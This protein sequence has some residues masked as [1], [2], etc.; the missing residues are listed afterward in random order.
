MILITYNI[1]GYQPHKLDRIVELAN[2]CDALILTEVWTEIPDLGPSFSVINCQAPRKED[3][4]VGRESGGVSFIIPALVQFRVLQRHTQQEF[5]A[6]SVSI[7]G[8]P[9]VGVYLRPKTVLSQLKEFQ[10]TAL[11]LARG[12]SVIIGDLNARHSLW[13][14]ITPQAVTTQ[15]RAI[16]NLAAKH[17]FRVIAA[18]SS[19]CERHNGTSR[20]D[21]AL[22]RNIRANY[23]RVGDF[24]QE[25]SDHAPVMMELAQCCPQQVD[26]I[27]LNLINNKRVRERVLEKYQESLP[28]ITRNL[29]KCDNRDDIKSLSR[30]LGSATLVPWACEYSPNPNRWRPGWTRELDQLA[31]KRSALLKK[32]DQYSIDRAR[33][34]DAQIKND[35]R[36]NRKRNIDQLG[37]LLESNIPHLDSQLTKSILDISKEEPESNVE[38]DPDEFTD[39]MQ[40]LQP[41]GAV[42]ITL[43][44]T[45][46]L[47]DSFKAS[48]R[49][50]IDTGKKKKAPGPDKARTEMIQLAPRL[51]TDACFELTRA[52]LRV[53]F[54]PSIYTSGNLRPI[55]KKKGSRE[56][57][58]NYRPINLTTS[59]RRI[60]SKAVLI[61]INKH[62][63]TATVQFGF[64]RGTGT[65]H[66]IAYLCN[67]LRGSLPEAA[68]LDQKKAFDK[69]PREILTR[70]LRKRFPPNLYKL[71]LIL[72]V[73]ILLRT[74]N[75]K[76]QR[77]AITLAGVP[78]GDP[79]S[80]TFFNIFMDEF[81]AATNISPRFGVICFAD[82]VALI[83]ESLRLLQ[84]LLGIASHWAPTNGMQWSLPKSFGL[85]L[86]KQ[87]TLAE[88]PMENK[89]ELEYLGVSVTRHGVSCTRL[90]RRVAAAH[91]RL[92]L[93][94]RH[95]FRFN[96]TVRQKAT[97]IKTFVMP[98]YDY[99]SYLHPL[100][101]ELMIAIRNLENRILNFVLATPIARH[102]RDKAFAIAQLL[103]FQARRGI[104]MAK[105]VAKT[106]ARVL[107]PRNQENPHFLRNWESLYRF[108]TI[109]A[110]LRRHPLPHNHSDIGTWCQAETDRIKLEQ[111]GKARTGRRHIPFKDGAH[112]PALESR[113]LSRQA[114][115][116]CTLWYL[117]R[118]IP[119]EQSRP[120]FP[121]LQS[122]LER[123]KLD[124]LD[125]DR[126]EQ[127]LLK[128]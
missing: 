25:Q 88:K 82:D 93:L 15:G 54:T 36:H 46:E 57:P 97:M 16:Y 11:R 119:N 125:E 17:K 90:L 10:K 18:P 96:L 113:N 38:V 120:L 68:L 116:K 115:K 104:Q 102:N 44:K 71:C 123:D 79:S 55:Y 107:T 8:T 32:S 33:L 29:A 64:K 69:M 106:Y 95:I 103:P 47:P 45:N 114:R 21:M 31:K 67:H 37:D 34:L 112:P 4:T 49:D 98:L 19:T 78:Q 7:R 6:L 56:D 117:N 63:S 89:R 83:A 99:V 42:P 70:L 2:E 48:I 118:L 30:E 124:Q 59:F 20:V 91:S 62:Y 60:L 1:R 50:A 39:Y 86:A 40:S 26:R 92:S 110:L 105:M 77:Y 14:T 87:L 22:A 12:S 108:G 85:G 75:Q 81:I 28:T 27:P 61:E 5:Q 43:E 58:A 76:S 52:T 109:A 41:E 3:G 111:W 126:L 24:D 65:A 9:V 128:F 73:P 80:P 101:G 35:V 53:G 51:F 127:L 84:E 72:L 100:G 94:F 74:I 13:D 66:S 121:Q 23:V 122:Y